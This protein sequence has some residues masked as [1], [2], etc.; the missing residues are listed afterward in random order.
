MGYES[1]LIYRIQNLDKNKVFRV[2]TT[3]IN[4]RKELDDL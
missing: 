2:L 3:R 1:E 4:D